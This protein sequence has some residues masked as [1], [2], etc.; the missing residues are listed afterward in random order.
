MN[1]DP[2]HETQKHTDPTDSDPQHVLKAYEFL[3]IFERMCTIVLQ[4]S[5][6]ITLVLWQIKLMAFTSTAYTAECTEGNLG[7]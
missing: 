4:I 3:C 1:S 7:M 5:G 6:Y 2:V